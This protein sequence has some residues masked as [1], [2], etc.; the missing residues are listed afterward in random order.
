MPK[1][2]KMITI[3]QER[4]FALFGPKMRVVIDDEFSILLPYGES[5]KIPVA[6]DKT[7]CNITTHAFGNAGNNIFTI[8]NFQNVKEIKLK[9]SSSG[10]KC[11][12]VY[13]NGL[14]LEALDKSS[15]ATTN[16]II[17]WIIMIIFIIIPLL[18]TIVSAIEY[19]TFVSTFD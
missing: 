3:T 5:A 13:N 11:S 17:F 19:T 8:K 16:R 14:T 1:E 7:E 6:K 4:G 10:C 2:D 18:M 9:T 15:G 12:V